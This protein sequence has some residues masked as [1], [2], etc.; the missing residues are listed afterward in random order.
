MDT[1][2]SEALLIGF[3]NKMNTDAAA[4]RTYLRPSAQ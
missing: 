3:E 4:R 2:G 1:D